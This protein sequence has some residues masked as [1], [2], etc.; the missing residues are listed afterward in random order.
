MISKTFVM[1]CYCSFS[2]HFLTDEYTFNFFDI[3]FSLQFISRSDKYLN[4]IVYMANIQVLLPTLCKQANFLKKKS[5]SMAERVN[6][7]KNSN[8]NYR[9]KYL[10]EHLLQSYITIHLCSGATDNILGKESKKSN[11]VQH[12]V[13]KTTLKKS[14]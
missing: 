11:Y 13:C 12:L 9:I 3:H 8:T 5:V 1:E 2:I 10:S 14:V 7:T 6:Y 4:S